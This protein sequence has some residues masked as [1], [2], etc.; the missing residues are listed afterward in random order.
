ML[1]FLKRFHAPLLLSLAMTFL[2]FTMYQALGV[3]LADEANPSLPEW[4]AS[5]VILVKDWKTLGIFA[6][7]AA[8]VKLLVDGTKVLGL[9]HKLSD[10][11]QM[12]VIGAVAT[13][14]VGLMAKAQGA[15]WIAA[16]V[17]AFQ[18][19]SG[20]MLLNEL[21]SA[22]WKKI[23]GSPSAPLAPPASPPP[24]EPK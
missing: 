8:G 21:V 13:L 3:A 18:S 24:V 22:I 23:T 4:I 17:A 10:I 16:G 12:L 2:L 7:L 14:S 15:S 20:A 19:A 1:N 5:A 6:G 11:G 9:F